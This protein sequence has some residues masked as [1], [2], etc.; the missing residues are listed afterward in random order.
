MT[1]QHSYDYPHPLEEG[2]KVKCGWRL[3][4]HLAASVVSGLFLRWGHLKTGP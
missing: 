3:A 2:I 4:H 1:L